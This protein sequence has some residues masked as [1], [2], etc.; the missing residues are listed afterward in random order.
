MSKW[1]MRL[2]ALG[3]ALA[4]SLIIFLFWG[5]FG[6]AFVRVMVIEYAPPKPAAT[7]PGEVSVSLPPPKSC[8]KGQACK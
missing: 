6:A 8:P 1:K 5:R 2:G 7:E 4:V 3:M